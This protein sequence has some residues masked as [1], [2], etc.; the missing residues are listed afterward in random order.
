M[1]GGSEENLIQ[2]NKIESIQLNGRG[3]YL[4]VT[5]VSNQI[6]NNIFS[7]SFGAAGRALLV[8]AG[9]PSTNQIIGN[10]SISVLPVAARIIPAY[11]NSAAGL[12]NT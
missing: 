12:M 2:S 1:S 11:L 4:D 7:G 8:S 9:T 3:V 5:G 6:S 10:Q